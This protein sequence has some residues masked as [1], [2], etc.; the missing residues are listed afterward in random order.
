VAIELLP[1]TCL[2]NTVEELGELIRRLGD[3]TFGVC[4]D[5]NHLMDRYGELPDEIRKLGPRLITTHLSDYDGVDEKHWLPGRGVID[6]KA[7]K[8][9]LGEIGYKGPFNYECHLPGDTPG[10]RIQAVEENFRWLGGV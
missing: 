8:E 9:A 4:L 10:E 1:R 3:E 5:V 2:G 7:V 6:W